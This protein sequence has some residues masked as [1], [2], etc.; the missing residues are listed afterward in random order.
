MRIVFW[1]EEAFWDDHAAENNKE[2]KG[3]LPKGDEEKTRE[4]CDEPQGA[5]R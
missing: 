1:P 2:N 4:K 3:Q 5:S